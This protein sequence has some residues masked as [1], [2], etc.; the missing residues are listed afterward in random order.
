MVASRLGW[1]MI[2]PGKRL[3]QLFQVILRL[4]GLGRVK[5][6]FVFLLGW[7]TRKILPTNELCVRRNMAFEASCLLCSNVVE[8]LA[9][10]L[11]DCPKVKEVWMRLLGH[12]QFPDSWNL[13]APILG[14][15]KWCLSCEFWGEKINQFIFLEILD[16]K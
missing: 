13:D 11:C 1:R 14:K 9:H 8:T 5:S 4:F 3:F 10:A 6:V 16:F 7:V 15:K 12:H 2:R